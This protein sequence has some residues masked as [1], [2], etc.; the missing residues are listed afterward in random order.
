MLHTIELMNRRSDSE[1]HC[2]VHNFYKF[3]LIV[4]I[5]AKVKVQTTEICIAFHRKKVTSE[6]LRY[7]SLLLAYECIVHLT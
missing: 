3:K 7:G 2:F 6:A 1:L 4:L 5:F